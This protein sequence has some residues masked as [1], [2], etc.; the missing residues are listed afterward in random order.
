MILILT[1]SSN[2]FFNDDFYLKITKHT[3]K[4][5]DFFGNK[6]KQLFEIKFFLFNLIQSI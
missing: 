6:N 3:L 2:D 4:K 1:L 5:S